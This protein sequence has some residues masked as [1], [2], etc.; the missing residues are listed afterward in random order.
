MKLG[1]QDYT[2]VGA[3]GVALVVYKLRSLGIP[4]QEAGEGMPFDV[5]A[6]P[7]GRIIRIQV[8][9]TQS[10]DYRSRFSFITSKGRRSC[11]PSN[12]RPLKAYTAGE[13]DLI[14]LAAL[15]LEAVLFR[16]AAQVSKRTQVAASKFKVPELERTTFEAAVEALGKKAH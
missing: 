8:K 9:A 11:D 6:F 13:V 1:P 4:A 3:Q 14:A 10:A 16:P 15:P 2:H 12:S 5:L 7:G